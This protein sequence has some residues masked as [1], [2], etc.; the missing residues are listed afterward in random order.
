M[1]TDREPRNT[2]KTRKG[3]S[4]FIRQFGIHHREAMLVTSKGRVIG[5]WQPVD[6]KLEEVNFAQRVKEYCAKPLPFTFAQ[7]L[8]EGKRR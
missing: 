7:L 2:L 5:A 1:N 8:K 6:K 3:N 4:A